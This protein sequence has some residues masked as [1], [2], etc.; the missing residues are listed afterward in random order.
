MTTIFSWMI[1]F[2]FKM[3][4][5]KSPIQY[6]VNRRVFSKPVTSKQ[7]LLNTKNLECLE[8]T[9]KNFLKQKV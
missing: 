2:E 1:L 9:S 8:G 5:K 3:F 6:W 7:H 4:T